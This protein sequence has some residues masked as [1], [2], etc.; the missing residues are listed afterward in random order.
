MSIIG[1]IQVIVVLVYG[2][3]GSVFG[4]KNIQYSILEPME[5]GL[6]MV[7]NDPKVQG[8]TCPEEV[9]EARE[10]GCV[11]L[12]WDDDS[13]IEM[14]FNQP[15][16]ISAESIEIRRCFSAVYTVNRKWRKSNDIIRKD[17]QC[18]KIGSV[19]VPQ[20]SA[21]KL[22]FKYTIPSDTAE[23]TYFIRLLA[24]CS[25]EKY[26]YCGNDDNYQSDL[27]AVEPM[28]SIPPGLVV[29]V[30]IAI[31]LAPTFLVA[32]FVYEFGFQKRM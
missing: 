17:K 25:D 28:D 5:L 26:D 2:L 8:R 12:S 6:T 13:A 7:F 11:T 18:K 14:S 29:G 22:S 4:D 10:V 21:E 19:D 16:N 1:T 27:Y 3:S 30:I 24:K 15:A 20:D 23:A 32:Y 9:I 31:I